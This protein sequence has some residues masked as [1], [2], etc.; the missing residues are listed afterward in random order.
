MPAEAP[1]IT[2]TFPSKRRVPEAE[3]RLTAAT[4]EGANRYKQWGDD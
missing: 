4:I 3:R 1:V 2:A